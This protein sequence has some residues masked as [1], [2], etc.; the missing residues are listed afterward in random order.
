MH[1]CCF[2]ELLESDT[3]SFTTAP[4]RNDMKI[5][6]VSSVENSLCSST[7][8]ILHL[9]E[10]QPWACSFMKKFWQIYMKISWD[11]EREYQSYFLLTLKQ[12]SDR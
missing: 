11:T 7:C 4:H 5:I 2:F 6:I 12:T 10:E 8:Y 3:H 9:A 1:V